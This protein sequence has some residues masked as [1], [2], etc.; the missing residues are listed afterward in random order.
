MASDDLLCQFRPHY[1]ALLTKTV[2]TMVMSTTSQS[3]MRAL[4]SPADC[5]QIPSPEQTRRLTMQGHSLV[6]VY[7]C[8]PI[9]LNFKVGAFWCFRMLH[10]ANNHDMWTAG[11]LRSQP[12][13]Q[14]MAHASAYLWC[15]VDADQRNLSRCGQVTKASGCGTTDWM[16]DDDDDA[17]NG[18]GATLCRV[19]PTLVEL[20]KDLSSQ[21][22]QGAQGTEA[23]KQT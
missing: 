23:R 18:L 3:N 6:H 22:W 5:H 17:D 14:L 1:L 16:L 10:H 21:K 11:A 13:Y 4:L 8:S 15:C 9:H 19:F 2:E 7:A 12:M 20:V